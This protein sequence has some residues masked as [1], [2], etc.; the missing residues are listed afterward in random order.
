MKQI[1]ECLN[2]LVDSFNS[3]IAQMTELKVTGTEKKQVIK[4]TGSFPFAHTIDYSDLDQKVDGNFVLAFENN[5]DAL[6]LANAIGMKLGLS[7]FKEMNEDSIDLIN[8]FLNILV[9]RT[10]SGW[11]EVGLSVKFGTPVSKK[12]YKHENLDQLQSHIIIFDLSSDKKESKSLD[13]IMIRVDFVEQN[14][15]TINGKK[16]LLVDDSK[17][18]R[19]LIAKVLKKEGVQIKEAGDGEEAIKVHKKF[20]PDL[21]MMD[22]NMPKMNGFESII[23]IR[24]F[25]PNSKFVILSSSS[26]K[27]EIMQVKTLKLSGYLI[28][29]V[30]PAILVKRVSEIL[31]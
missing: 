11:D 1:D 6:K 14:K 21:T 19:G 28:K 4:D 29:P 10:I 13:Q 23:H 25:N 31:A 16:M 3:T 27:E 20:N 15:N 2:I 7:S 8:E 5:I 12:N 22:I 24:T 18:M 30:D 26:K 17:V 9:G